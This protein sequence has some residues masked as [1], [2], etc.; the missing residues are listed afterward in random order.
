MRAVPGSPAESQAV[1]DRET[2]CFQGSVLLPSCPSPTTSHSQLSF[3]SGDPEDINALETK[4]LAHSR[5]WDPL[6]SH[7]G[8]TQRSAPFY[9]Q[10]VMGPLPLGFLATLEGHPQ[11]VR[12]LELQKGRGRVMGSHQ[13]PRR[14][15]S[16][17]IVPS[18][19]RKFCR[20]APQLN[21]P[22]ISSGAPTVHRT[23]CSGCCYGVCPESPH[24][25]LSTPVPAGLRAPASTLGRGSEPDEPQ[26]CGSQAWS[27][28]KSCPL[29][30]TREWREGVTSLI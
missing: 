20:M 6:P 26:A 2:R 7:Y 15:D 22:Q 19:K 11:W 8:L 1:P 23:Q 25:A 18:W 12:G 4:H 9:G 3:S 5:C 28:P 14:E 24:P 21:C 30:V 10:T 29:A 16:S 13:L 27:S 17:E